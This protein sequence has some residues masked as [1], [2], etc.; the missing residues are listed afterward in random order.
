MKM[1]NEPT[2]TLF[3]SVKNSDLLAYFQDLVLNVDFKGSYLN[4]PIN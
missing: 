4:K 1:L 3:E 2:K